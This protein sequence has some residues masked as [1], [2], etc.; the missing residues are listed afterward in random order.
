[1]REMPFSDLLA[2]LDNYSDWVTAEVSPP[3]YSLQPGFRYNLSSITGGAALSLSVREHFDTQTLMQQ[4]TLDD[5]QCNA[6]VHA[7]TNRLALIQGPPGTG[8][9]YVGINIVKTL[10][11]NRE[12]AKLGPVIC[13]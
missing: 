8:K 4:S 7:L 10:L 11:S 2:P 12:V 13:V 9:S 6:L 5:A 1:L 3:A